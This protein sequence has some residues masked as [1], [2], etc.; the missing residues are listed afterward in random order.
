M[1]K[2]KRNTDNDFEIDILSTIREILNERDM[3][4]YELAKRCKIPQST[5]SN[6]FYK[7]KNPSIKTIMKI[8]KGLQIEVYELFGYKK[9]TMGLSYNELKLFSLWKKLSPEKQY[10]LLVLLDE[11]DTH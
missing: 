4:V 5:L 1:S 6:L 3:T 10:A 8:C 7:T 2:S 9:D 11:N